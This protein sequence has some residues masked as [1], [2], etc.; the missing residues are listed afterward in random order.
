MMA[1]ALT[2]LIVNGAY[3]AAPKSEITVSNDMITLADVFDGVT[4]NHGYV[5]APAP[6]P[7]KTKTLNADDLQRIS[8]AF[9]LGWKSQ[10]GL[11]QA[12]IRRDANVIDRYAIE[13]ELQEKLADVLGG[14]KFDMQL[15]DRN[16]KINLSPDLPATVEAEDVTYDKTRGEFRAVLFAPS[17]ANPVVKREVRG[18]F[19]ALTGIPVL[20]SDLRA[21]DII[22]ANDIVYVDTPAREVTTATIVSA[23]KL[24]GMTPRRGLAA[25]KQVTPADIEQPLVVKKGDV[26]TM[27]LKSK[28]MSLTAQG[29]ALENGAAGQIVRIINT[30]S[31]QVV[32]GIVTGPQAVTVMSPSATLASR[33]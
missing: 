6:E 9:S 29:K 27:T 19:S 11:D 31:N 33:I 10:N 8:D 2:A 12:V 1:A 28:I 14:G 7:G 16:V 17:A 20:K 25:G 26:V 23:E 4:E 5:L 21:G 30:S 32:E 3:A 15:S 24:V 13:A 18:R 22:S